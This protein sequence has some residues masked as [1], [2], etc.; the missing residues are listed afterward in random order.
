MNNEKNATTD[1]FALPGVMAASEYILHIRAQAYR[2]QGRAFAEFVGRVFGPMTAALRKFL[3]GN[4][5]ADELA[6]MSDHDLADIGIS[7]GDIF[8]ANR[9]YPVA[10]AS[11]PEIIGL[12]KWTPV[13]GD[14][15]NDGNRRAA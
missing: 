1:I 3:A 4:G 11:G 2:E 5:A 12:G 15:S 6:R 14:A 10:A 8:Q 9:A 7:R 13:P